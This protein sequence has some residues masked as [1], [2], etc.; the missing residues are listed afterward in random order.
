MTDFPIKM[1]HFIFGPFIGD[2]PVKMG[3][4]DFGPFIGG[5]LS[6]VICDPVENDLDCR[7]D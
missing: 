2:F 4:V 5:F 1:R 6:R 7:C 3:M